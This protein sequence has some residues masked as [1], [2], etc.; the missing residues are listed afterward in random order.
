MK[1]LL[2]GV[3]VFFILTILCTKSTAQQFPIYPSTYDVLG[4]FPKGMREFGADTLEAFGKSFLSFNLILKGSIF[5]IPRGGNLTYPSEYAP[6]GHTTWMSVESG[7]SGLVHI[8][9]PFWEES[10]LQSPYGW[11][12]LLWKGWALGDIQIPHD[13]W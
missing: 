12:S 6:N 10:F 3:V 7:E 13:G 11:S 9:Y 5:N 8:N 2:S 4:P 1:T